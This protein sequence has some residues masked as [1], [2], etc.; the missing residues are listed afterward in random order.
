VVTAARRIAFVLPHLEAGGIERV[1]LN[2]LI[3]LDRTRFSPVLILFRRK[4]TMLDQVPA[5]VPVHDLGGR[6]ARGV[7]LPLARALAQSGASV[8]YTGTN[9]A[10][11]STL[12]AAC[13]RRS[14]PPVIIS[15]HTPPGLYLAEAK[16]PGLRR[17]LMGLLYPRAATLAVP[18]DAIGQEIRRILRCPD[19]PVACV[20]NP[21]VA[22]V[23][24]PVF[25]DGRPDRGNAAAG[26]PAFVSAG[27]L[28]PAKGFDLLLEAFALLRASM[29]ATTLTIFGE[30][31]ERGS[32]ETLCRRLRIEDAVRMPGF[33]RDP[34]SSCDRRTIFVLSSRREGF[35]NVL[36]EA[37]AAGLPVVA[38]DCPVG[39]RAILEDGKFGLLVPPGDAQ[40]LSAAMRRLA[41]DPG[42]AA[43]LA[44][45]GPER[46]GLYDV[47]SAVGRFADLFDSVADAGRPMRD[48]GR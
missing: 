38:A 9:A 18:L 19:L 1:V 37:M 30:G 32:L 22:R 20:P 3:H 24:A 40:A 10:N 28:V 16:M 4:G 26:E 12:L 39:P 15:E 11:I 31:P 5:D 45:G 46:A 34:L 6:T 29:P 36:I 47:R 48:G 41:G 44:A 8:V 7:A 33:V 27:R 23:V 17:R 13:L 35:G 43:A 42:Y 25:G 14:F 2:L 21:V